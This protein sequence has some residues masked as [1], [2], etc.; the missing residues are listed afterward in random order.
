MAA[1][2]YIIHGMHRP[3]IDFHICIK[4]KCYFL[5][6]QM[7]RDTETE[8]AMHRP[9][10]DHTLIPSITLFSS[11]I[12]SEEAPH[13][14]TTHSPDSHGGCTRV[15]RSTNDFRTKPNVEEKAFAFVWASDVLKCT[16]RCK[17][18]INTSHPRASVHCSQQQLYSLL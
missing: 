18:T 2:C 13:H 10:T 12:E 7:H 5:Q 8:R 3:K 11:Q 16:N 4:G 14:P 15:R 17:S 9:R 6:W 1:V